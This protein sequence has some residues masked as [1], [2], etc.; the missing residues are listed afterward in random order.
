MDVPSTASPEH[1]SHDL[2][3]VGH[4]NIDHFIEVE[5][6]PSADRTVP[7]LERRKE[8]GGTAA[9]IARVAAREGLRVG[10][11]SRLGDDFPPDFLDVLRGEKLDLEGLEF[12][13]GVSSSACMIVED[14][15]G[16]QMTFIDQGPMTDASHAPI[17]E[18][19]VN[20][21]T[22]VHLTTGDP[23]YQLRMAELARS[24][25]CHVAADPAQEIHYRWSSKELTRLLQYS[26]ML[27]VNGSEAQRAARMMGVT[28]TKGLV[29]Y[30]PLI[31]MTR[32]PRG[33]VAYFRG[34]MET[35]PAAPGRR[36]HR[37][38]GAGDAFRG[39]FYAAWIRGTPL[40]RALIQGN[41]SAARWIRRGS[42]RT[43]SRGRK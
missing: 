26:E 14:R 32:G 7:I 11:V 42:Q 30:V 15:H 43:G 8:L 39:G 27:F 36:P 37:L 10:L 5:S 28:S 24:L 4:I 2:L 21:S 9:T 3:V 23:A 41:R 38:T 12:V 34:G 31:V 13:K 18:T 29:R 19:V 20:G 17:P 40:R 16:S 35:V 6:L 1:R 25:G 33:A 22:W